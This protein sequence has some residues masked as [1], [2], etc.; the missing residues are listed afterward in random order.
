[1][2]DTLLQVLKGDERP[3]DWCDEAVVFFSAGI[4]FMG[5]LVVGMCPSKMH[6]LGLKTPILC[7][8]T[9]KIEILSTYNLLCWKIATFCSA[10]RLC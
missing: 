1:M 7:K 8:F 4:E 6:N 10:P 5:C 9:C 3:S 2:W